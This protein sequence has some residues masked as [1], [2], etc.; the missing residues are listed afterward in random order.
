MSLPVPARVAGLV[1]VGVLVLF[2]VHVVRRVLVERS[3]GRPLTP[4]RILASRPSGVA[5]T[6]ARVWGLATS[7]LIVEVNGGRH[8]TLGAGFPAGDAAATL[9]TA[10]N[11]TDRASVRAR[12]EW[13]R[14][15]GDRARWEALR[16]AFNEGDPELEDRAFVDPA[17]R[18]QL[19]VINRFGQRHPS[20]PAWDLCRAVTLAR[21]AY[22]AG[23]I[24]E[25]E[26]WKW[27]ERLA[28]VIRSSFS[29]WRE[30]TEN[31]M[32]GREFAQGPADPDLHAA[33]LYLLD[34]ANQSSPWNRL[35]WR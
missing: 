10:W 23:F 13:L 1:A 22:G 2:L 20:L 7:A 18:A 5:Q 34:P 35:P 32:V 29:S 31:Y 9:A 12:L 4:A 3:S 24:A 33:Q 28:P 15:S 17:L 19:E 8:D 21:L 25:G 30:M 14:S 11:C 26:S 6:P 27:V 16:R